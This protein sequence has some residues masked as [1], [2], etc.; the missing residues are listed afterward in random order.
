MTCFTSICTTSPG[1]EIFI[2]RGNLALGCFAAF[3]LFREIFWLMRYLL[4]KIL[5]VVL[6]DVLRRFGSKGAILYFDQAVYFLRNLTT[7]AI[8][9][10]EVVGCLTLC[11]LF[12][13]SSRPRGPSKETRS[14]QI[15]IVS[16]VMPKCLDVSD[17]LPPFVLIQSKTFNRPLA[18]ALKLPARNNERAIIPA[19]CRTMPYIVI[20]QPPYLPEPRFFKGFWA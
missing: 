7:S 12:D 2:P 15:R 5:P 10:G 11:G 4:F 20:R 1:P 9:S 3:H 16:L 6:T 17:T 13:L 14:L 18:F 19:P 8:M